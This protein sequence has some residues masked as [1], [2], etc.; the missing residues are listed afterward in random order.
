MSFI[1]P[2][3]YCFPYFFDEL[4]F[5]RKIE[6]FGLQYK[7]SFDKEKGGYHPLILFNHQDFNL[8]V[9]YFTYLMFDLNCKLMIWNTEEDMINISK[10]SINDGLVNKT[11][12]KMNLKDLAVGEN[13]LDV[14]YGLSN[15]VTYVRKSDIKYEL[16]YYENFA[17][18]II[19][20]ESINIIPF[21]WFNKTG[22]DY[23]YVWPATAKLNLRSFEL[24][25]KGMRMGDFKIQLHN[26]F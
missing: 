26:Q 14:D 3:Q 5:K 15:F 11:D 7:L 24:A 19:N 1:T 9:K 20:D 25:G 8:S 4:E 13:K 10:M 21:D 12:F 16:D 2:T 6:Q 17:I 22:G 23:G 18:V